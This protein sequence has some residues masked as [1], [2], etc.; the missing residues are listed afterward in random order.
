MGFFTIL[1]QFLGDRTRILDKS[2]KNCCYFQNT[3]DS[4]RS[5]HLGTSSSSCPEITERTLHS[6][7]LPWH[8]SP[9]RC[10]AID[11]VVD[12]THFAATKEPHEQ[13]SSASPAWD[14]VVK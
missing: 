14:H 9:S 1:S 11:H 13:G 5:G 3:C 7:D 6:G 2:T 10:A 12:E 8:Q 4:V